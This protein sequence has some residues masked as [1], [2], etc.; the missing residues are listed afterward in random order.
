MKAVILTIMG[1]SLAITGC[2]SLSKAECQVADWYQIGAKDGANGHD[3]N[4]LASH[5]KACTK[6]GV[7]PDRDTWERGRQAGLYS[8]CT[9][10]NAYRVGSQGSSLKNVCPLELQDQLNRATSY[11]NSIYRLRRNLENGR[12]E[13]STLKDRLKK[14]QE[15]DNLEFKTEKEARAYM[16]QLPAK[17]RELEANLAYYD[18]QLDQ[19]IANNPFL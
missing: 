2:A 16:L 15:G 17:I 8:Y 1:A 14:L 3:W 19:A 11:G 5:A 18:A 10:A 6:V 4:R 9:P 7:T 12:K 13:L